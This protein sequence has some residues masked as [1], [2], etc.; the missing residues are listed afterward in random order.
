MDSLLTV[1]LGVHISP[2]F[3]SDT[4]VLKLNL[5]SGIVYIVLKELVLLLC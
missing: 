1:S 2:L 3:V 5:F 4:V